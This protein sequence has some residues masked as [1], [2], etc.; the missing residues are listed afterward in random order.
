MKLRIRS[1]T[2]RFRLGREDVSILA[3]GGCIEERIRFGPEPENA[4]VYRVEPSADP[5]R[6]VLRYRAGHLTL[7]LGLPLCRALSDPDTTGFEETVPVGEGV[8]V[9]IE[10]DF[11]CLKPRNPQE[12]EGAFPHPLAGQQKE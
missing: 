9:L 3:G 5:A 1:N 7:L 6:M 12:D 11:A 8:H 10:K 2:L 4:F